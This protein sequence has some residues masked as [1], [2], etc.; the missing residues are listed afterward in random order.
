MKAL[1]LSLSVG[2]LPYINKT[3]SI[4]S[5]YATIWLDS[6]IQSSMKVFKENIL[7]IEKLT[8]LGN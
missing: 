4:N 7:K 8:K 3:D 5:F 6:I 2:T 1:Q